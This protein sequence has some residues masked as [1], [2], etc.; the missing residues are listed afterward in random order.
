[1]NF[2]CTRADVQIREALADYAA[3]IYKIRD[4]NE[5]HAIWRHLRHIEVATA[6]LVNSAG[7]KAE[8]VA[9]ESL[10]EKV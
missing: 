1:M 7:E 6:Q 10:M 2:V 8:R 4:V 9:G 5:L 3:E